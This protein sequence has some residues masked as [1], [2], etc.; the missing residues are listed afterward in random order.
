MGSVCALCMESI[1]GLPPVICS[2][3]GTAESPL[4]YTIEYEKRAVKLRCDKDRAGLATDN[5]FRENRIFHFSNC[6]YYGI[7]HR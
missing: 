7:I 1:N 2:S 4:S 6:Y 3:G 5:F